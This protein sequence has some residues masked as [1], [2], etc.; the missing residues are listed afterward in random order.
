[1]THLPDSFF[2]VD[3]PMDMPIKLRHPGCS[4]GKS[5]ALVVTRTPSGWI[6]YCHRCGQSGKRML[7]GLS[8][9]SMAKFVASVKPEQKGTVDEVRLPQDV[10]IDLPDQ[11][12]VWLYSYGITDEQMTKY[13]FVWSHKLSRLFMPVYDRGKLV[14]YQGRAIPYTKGMTE[15]YLNVRQ[16]GRSNI[17]FRVEDYSSGQVVL[18][19]DIL[20]A[21]RVGEITNAIGLLYAYVPDQLVIALSKQYND[22]VIWLDAD[23]GNYTAKKLMRFRSFGIPVRRVYTKKDPKCYNAETIEKEIEKWKK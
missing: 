19:E 20:S 2:D 14:Y 23:K 17:L 15:K 10:T 8:S 13:R 7:N 21:I 11:A 1:M 5:K 3:A 9:R 22:I 4:D 12:K 6:W 18:V 16:K